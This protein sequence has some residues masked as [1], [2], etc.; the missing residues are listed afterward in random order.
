MIWLPIVEAPKD[1]TRL[2]LWNGNS[3][4]SA[5]YVG[6]HGNVPYRR[7]GD[8]VLGVVQRRWLSEPGDY[9]KRPRFWMPLP[10]L[11]MQHG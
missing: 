10:E 11:K 3:D 4:P 6:Y 8:K 9:I 7:P 2:L 1:G 5:I